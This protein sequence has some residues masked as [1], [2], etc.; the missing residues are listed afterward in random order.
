MVKNL[1]SNGTYTCF[2]GCEKTSI[3]LFGATMMAY[4]DDT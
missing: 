4:S 3:S 1:Q 2:D